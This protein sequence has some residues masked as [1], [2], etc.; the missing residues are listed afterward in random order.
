MSHRPASTPSLEELLRLTE[1]VHCCATAEDRLPEALDRLGALVHASAVQ[2]L[3]IDKTTGAVL[4]A[5][6]SDPA[7]EAANRDYVSEW[8]RFDPRLRLA[9]SARGG[10][11]LA[12]HEH[13][14]EAFVAQDHFFQ[15]FLGAHGL[16]WSLLGKFDA[17]PGVSTV[18]VVMRDAK[19]A[20]FEPAAAQMLQ[21]L[22]PHFERA[23]VTARVLE[24]YAGA[25]ESAAQALRIMPV[26][27]L[28]T[29]HV[30]RCMEGNEAFS[31]ALEPLFLRIVTG[32][33]RFNDP[34]LQD[35]WEAALFETH[36]T[37][38]PKAMQF[39]TPRGQEWKLRLLP[40]HAQPDVRAGATRLILAVFDD[41][42]SSK[43]AE[44]PAGSMAAVARLT[45]AEAEVLAG[46]L[47]GMP[48][49]AIAARRNASVHTVRSQIMA[50]L[51]KTGYN[52]QKELMASFGTSALPDSA[53]ASSAFHSDV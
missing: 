39:A 20:P 16:R 3:T 44:V 6:M 13:L 19:Q 50:I 24:R 26:P 10:D 27:C 29:D 28:I 17:A 31:R 41:H 14:D 37:A 18:I 8:A 22:L 34:A 33:V 9:A 46:L 45:R 7:L 53:F 35:R 43:A 30:G 48:A 23:M 4:D 11:V 1:L 42:V 21:L 5:R 38:L 25:M 49:K 47:K 36:A 15:G 32:R 51:E 52:S 40:W 12:C 2:V